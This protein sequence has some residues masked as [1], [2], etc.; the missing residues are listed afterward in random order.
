MGAATLTTMT[1]ML[2]MDIGDGIGDGVDGD[3][4]WGVWRLQRQQW[5]KIIFLCCI[6]SFLLLLTLLLL[7]LLLIFSLGAA[8]NSPLSLGT[9]G[10]AVVVIIPWWCRHN[11]AWSCAPMRWTTLVLLAV[12]FLSL[13]LVRDCNGAPGWI[14]LPTIFGMA[15]ASYF[16]SSFC[17]RS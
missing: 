10:V 8:G 3:L 14:M 1:N 7:S 6:V 12:P 9:Y 15:A 11:T 16:S 5:R 4:F 13:L 17:A 2:A